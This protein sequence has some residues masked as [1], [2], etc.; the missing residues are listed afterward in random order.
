MARTKGAINKNKKLPEA[1]ELITL[2]ISE[3]EK[4]IKF[5][6]KVRDGKLESTEDGISYDN[7]DRLGAA[8]SLADLG[9]HYLSLADSKGWLSQEEEEI[10][11]QKLEEKEK[12]ET[13]SVFEFSTYKK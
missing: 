13:N 11:E 9:K 7:K 10:K 5:L 2:S 12:K 3:M 1:L 8:K 6:S 4:S